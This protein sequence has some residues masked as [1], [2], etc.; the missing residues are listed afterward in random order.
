LIF[1]HGEGIIVA[2]G[3]YETFLKIKVA[4]TL[5]NKE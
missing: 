5:G 2:K 3:T 4:T 1:S